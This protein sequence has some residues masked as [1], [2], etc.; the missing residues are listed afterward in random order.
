MFA[1]TGCQALPELRFETER[2]RIGTS[3]DA[4]I[5]EG[6]LDSF[7]DHVDG[8]ERAL[9][10]PRLDSPI[11]V[12]WLDDV[13]DY[14]GEASGGCFYPGTRVLFA[15]EQSITHEIVHAV[16]DSTATSY[17][18]EEGI[19]EMYSGADVYYRP[20]PSR[21]HP[22]EALHMT[23][24]QYR[25]GGLDYAAAAHFMRFVYDRKG[26]VAMKRLAENIADADS[27][28]A[29]EAELERLFEDDIADIENHYFDNAS[30][31]YPGFA[32]RTVEVVE[33][34]DLL[35]GYTVELDCDDDTTRGP[36]RPDVGGVYQVRRL[37]IT[38]R[39]KAEITVDGDAGGRVFIFD[40]AAEFGTVTNWSM[41]EPEI[42][43]NAIEVRVG[44]TL[45][46]ELHP[47]VHLVV[48]TADDD[49]TEI[50][51]RLEMDR[52]SSPV[53]EQG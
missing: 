22:A 1:I 37:D 9:G 52:P 32:S 12:Y 3:F 27:T 34:G 53:G 35:D 16:L 33:A 20:S 40:P 13:S 7:D 17:F 43:P 44:E 29:I 25:A 26:E 38:R 36:L 45:R 19:A 2:L 15:R 4:P 23:R 41:P 39:G 6:T 51:L 8:V 42:D 48:F 47:G 49:R 11:I 21:T 31:Y 24:S 30:W 10:Q 46:A 14:C 28:R 18:V 5:C 50:E